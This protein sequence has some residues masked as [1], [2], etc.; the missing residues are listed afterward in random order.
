MTTP[1]A[2]L[3]I[4]GTAPTIVPRQF[5]KKNH[6][7]IFFFNVRFVGIRKLRARP[8]VLRAGSTKKNNKR[9]NPY[10]TAYTTRN[11]VAK[12]TNRSTT[13]CSGASAQ[14]RDLFFLGVP[15]LTR[16]P[17][18]LILSFAS[19]GLPA[20]ST[21]GDFLAIFWRLKF[22]AIELLRCQI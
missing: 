5:S 13:V 12:Q 3:R 6:T 9:K 18:K 2:W 16:F 1:I 11:S 21:I 8:E 7:V 19:F 20:T 15:I 14:S 17:A 22:L 10:N 4:D